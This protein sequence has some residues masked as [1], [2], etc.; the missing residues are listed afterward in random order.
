MDITDEEMLEK[1]YSTIYASNITLQQQYRLRGF[2]KYF[3][4]ISSLLTA[5]KNN[6]LLIKNHQS[7]STSSA[8]FTEANAAFSKHYE[9]DII[10]VLAVDVVVA[11][12]VDAIEVV[13]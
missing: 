5:E 6:K 1:T 4:L 2:K 7:R 12:I 8:A 9:R 3:E 10:M 13:L 11:M